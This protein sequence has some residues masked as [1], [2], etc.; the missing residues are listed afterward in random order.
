MK[1]VYESKV[2]WNAKTD[3]IHC[4]PSFHGSPRY[5]FVLIDTAEGEIFAQL[6]FIFVCKIDG[7]EYP[8]ALIHS[9]DEPIQEYPQKD[10]D[11]GL[12]R[13]KAR[14]RKST[15]IISVESIIRGALVVSDFETDDQY[16]VVDSVDSDMFLRMQEL[17]SQG[18]FSSPES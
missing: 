2:D 16:F 9:Y 13:I 4:S 17:L 11:L 15:E 18:L 3:Y 14:N 7:K 8:L 5:D 12:Y 10:I 6:Q 1:V